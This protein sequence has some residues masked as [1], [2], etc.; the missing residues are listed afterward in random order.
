MLAVLIMRPR[1]LVLMC[2]HQSDTKFFNNFFFFMNSS[3]EDNIASFDMLGISM[4]SFKET[5]TNEQ[6]S[7]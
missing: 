5:N 7:L 6:E 1:V 3:S 2:S 4:Y